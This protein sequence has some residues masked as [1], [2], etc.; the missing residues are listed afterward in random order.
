MSMTSFSKKTSGYSRHSKGLHQARQDNSTHGTNGQAEPM[1]LARVRFFAQLN[2][3]LPQEK[4]G[5]EMEYEFEVSGSVKDAIEALGVPHTEIDIIV[6]NGESVDFSYRL[7]DGDRVSVYPVFQSIDVPSLVHLRPQVPS[8]MH[9]ILDTHLGK[10]AAYLRMLGFDTKYSNAFEDDELAQ[11][12]SQEGRILLTRDQGLLKRSIIAHGYWVRAT[13][14]REQ[15]VEIVNYFDLVPRMIPFRRCMHCNGLL[16][17]VSKERIIDRLQ[18]ETR[19]HHDEFYICPDCERIY[20][21][22]SHY[23]RMRNF[24][25]KIREASVPLH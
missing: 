7:R 24:I 16:E 12:S 22:G 9:F 2:D 17:G 21:K 19:Q 11:I 18:P 6:V 23:D 5:R 3:F 25:E 1:K 15:V 13:M 10:L 4:R 8:D 14:P 20:W